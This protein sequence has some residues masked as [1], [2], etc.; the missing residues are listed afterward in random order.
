MN[1]KIEELRKQLS[2]RWAAMDTRERR[3]VIGAGALVALA[4]LWWVGVQPAL[5][6][7]RETPARLAELDQQLLQMRQLAKE[8]QELKDLPSVSASTAGSALQASTERL[9]GKARLNLQ[10][11]RA[12]LTLN[13]LRGDLLW[14]WLSEARQTARARP[15]EAK[16]S[17]GAEGYTG[18]LVLSLPGTP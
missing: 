7:L 14:Q 10:G 16:L 12:T 1:A 6:T 2:T 9:E 5:R 3:L 18:T 8:S 11:D 17:H 4:L 13:G 15:I